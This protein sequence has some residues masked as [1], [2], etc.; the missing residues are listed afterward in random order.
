MLADEY[1]ALSSTWMPPQ[2]A[3]FAVDVL[4]EINQLL[5]LRVNKIVEG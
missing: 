3:I 1:L 2:E 5:V 4:T